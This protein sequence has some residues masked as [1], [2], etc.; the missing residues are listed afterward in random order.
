VV[1]SE[2]ATAAVAEVYRTHYRRLVAAIYAATGDYDNAQDAVQEAFAGAVDRPHRFLAAADPHAYLRV[3]ALNLARQRWRR[4]RIFDRLVR[5]GRVARPPDTM[6]GLT[7]ERVDLERAL[8]RLP[9]PTREAIV[10]H[11]LLDL[12][13]TQVAEELGVPVGT[14]K[15]RLVRGRAQL[16]GYLDDAAYTITGGSG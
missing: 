4:Q 1:S 14:V 7:G 2:D 3:A 8:R 16:S 10:L 15:A 12:P 5:L 11:H 9:R 6:P 13:V